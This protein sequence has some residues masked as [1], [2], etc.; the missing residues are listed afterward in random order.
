MESIMPSK[1]SVE[2]KNMRNEI[3]FPKPK[4]FNARLILPPKLTHFT[5]RQG[6]HLFFDP[7]NHIWIRLN[8]SGKEVIEALEKCS[9]IDEVI[10]TVAVH[11][12]L[13]PDRI[14]GNVVRFIE[15]MVNVGIVHV[16]QY[17]AREFI[18][19]SED[20][21]PENVYFSNTER[22]NL[23]C[24][25]C[26]NAE[27]RKRFGSFREEMTTAETITALDRFRE[28]G[29]SA[30]AFCG[31]E[32]MMRSDFLQIAR[33][34]KGRGLRVAL[35]TNGTYI[36]EKLAPVVAELFDMVWVSL[37]SHIKEHHE[38]LRGKGS[39]DRTMHAVRMLAS[40]DTKKL[41][42]NSVV[43]NVNVESMPETHRFFTEEIG[44]R[45][46]RMGAF[47]PSK[48]LVRDK[49]GNP[50]ESVL[51]NDKYRDFILEAGL[52]LELGTEELPELTLDKKDGQI[53]KKAPRRNQ[54]GFASG[55][56]HMVS[57]GD[58]YPCVMTYKSEFRA[59]NILREDIRKI[60]RESEVLK[61]CREVT[62]DSIKPCSDCFVKYV[63]GGGCRGSAHD[64]Y[65]DIK[66]YHK[67]LCSQLKKN[68]IDSLWLDS[69][70]PFA[71]MEQAVE[72][73][74]QKLM[75][76][77]K[78]QEND[79]INAPASEETTTSWSLKGVS[80]HDGNQDQKDI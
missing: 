52:K 43:C 18:D 2:F 5:N 7:E 54:C 24:V 50:L 23:S 49:N 19:P 62:V 65:G 9:I 67:D 1:S 56:I 75:N 11:H 21:H 79:R 38:A 60:Y 58:I 42:V 10:R 76:F 25:Y 71:K 14:R 55:D 47:L 27:S 61:K 31:G 4:L 66:A 51:F 36:T 13:D 39:F 15:R 78:D 41:I 40:Y 45:Q 64:M 77:K 59:G 44:I 53:M 48:Q 29:A 70:I 8:D 80:R 3:P 35:V 30:V 37:D 33:Y 68:A 57:N 46:H 17:V 69:Q 73:Y 22:C 72:V 6:W 63:C 16:N 20:I 26:Y 74:R 28:F 32:P 12:G 34:V